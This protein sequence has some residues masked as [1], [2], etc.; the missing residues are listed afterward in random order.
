MFY[1]TTGMLFLPSI[2]SACKK[3]TL[4]NENNFSGEV[5]IIGAG[6]SGLYAAKIL[7]EFGIKSTILEA[8][9]RV[10]G[11]IKTLSG[12][13][14]FDIELGADEIIGEN[15]M[16]HD[17][18]LAGGASFVSN[19]GSPLYYFNGSIKNEIE[20]SQN[21][22]FNAM[23]NIIASIGDYAG[24]DVT[25]EVFA[26]LSGV[27]DNVF[28]I[29]NAKVANAVG[30]CD[31]RMGM[32]GL[33]TVEERRTS[34]TTKKFIKNK[35]L[36]SILD[37][38]FSKEIGNVILNSRIQSIDYSDAKVTVTDEVGNV[39]SADKVIITVPIGVLQNNDIT[40]TPELPVSHSYAIQQIGFDQGMKI[41]VKFDERVWPTNT[42]VIYG[43]G[44]IPEFRTT[45]ALERSTEDRWL[46]AI[47]NGANAETLSAQGDGMIDV[48]L[49]E[50]DQVL[51]EVSMHY[52]D[53][54]IQNWG[55]DPLFRGVM[56]YSKP[57][58]G[59]SRTTLTQPINNKIYF[60]GEA[61]HDGGHHGT[62]HGAMESALRSVIDIIS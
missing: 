25:A 55:S 14:D 7:N 21:T 32:F 54:V 39:Y 13:A 47:V 18:V 43:S 5:I 6:I 17:M 52:V 40:F 20:A 27:S 57:G 60:A 9:D 58:T 45:A 3:T 4:Q 29:F 61:V 24:S 38:Q 37:Q 41:I 53:H 46:T 31:E 1:G 42:G 48:V 15:S 49:G 36:K 30:S 22:F 23:N 16:W 33:R 62:V 8:S 50:I 28:H 12:Y 56:S 59:N 51:G 10:G 34:G 35:G 26:N 44:L 11:R 2:L 19:S